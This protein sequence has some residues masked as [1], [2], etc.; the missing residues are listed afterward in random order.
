M[1][2]GIKDKYHGQQSLDTYTMDRISNKA[3]PSD[4]SAT[5]VTGRVRS[6]VAKYEKKALSSFF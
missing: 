2:T 4:R 3:A 1:Y 5:V 6:K